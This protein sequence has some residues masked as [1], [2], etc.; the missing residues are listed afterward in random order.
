MGAVMRQACRLASIL[1][2]LLALAIQSLA[3]QPHLHFT[4]LSLAAM[5]AVADMA[6]PSLPK[7][8]RSPGGD[9][10]NCP[11]CQTAARA[12]DAVLPTAIV[13]FGPVATPTHASSAIVSPR[14]TVLSHSWR[15]RAP[16]LA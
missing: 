3:V 6:K 9:S 5:S 8:K 11:L 12:G 2:A 13:F 7:G 14:A 16:P 15:G 10:A 1:P 4:R